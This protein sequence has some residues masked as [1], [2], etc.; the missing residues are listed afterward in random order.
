MGFTQPP[1]YQLRITTDSTN[2]CKKSAVVDTECYWAPQI[3]KQA[4]VVLTN[5]SWTERSVYPFPPVPSLTKYAWTKVIYLVPLALKRSVAAHRFLNEICLNEGYLSSPE[6]CR[7]NL[8]TP[9]MFQQFRFF[10]K[11][12]LMGPKMCCY[13]WFV[14]FLFFICL[15]CSLFLVL[16]FWLISPY[17]NRHNPY[18]WFCKYL[19]NYY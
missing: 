4:I 19:V 11:F 9:C 8:E 18:T 10:F 14:H 17:N 3:N 2:A 16:K 13:C 5:P 12:V 15:M 1:L 6:V 7:S